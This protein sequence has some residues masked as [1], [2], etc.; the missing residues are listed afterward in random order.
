MLLSIALSG[1][2]LLIALIVIIV[3]ICALITVIFLEKRRP[4]AAF[5][6]CL[7]IIFIPI[8]GFIV[9]IFLGRHF[10]HK[11][12]F[13][14]KG[15]A[16]QAL[17][18]YVEEELSSAAAD[19]QL[20]HKGCGGFE[21]CA[22]ALLK[23]DNALL[24]INNKVDVYRDG[25]EKFEA[26][27]DAIR[28]AKH[29]VHIEYFI[30]RDDELGREIVSV[31]AEKAKEG[32]EVRALFDAGGVPGGYKKLFAPILENCG[33]VR[34]FF[35]SKLPVSPRINFHDHR[36]ILVIDGKLGF[37]GG[38]N[39]GDEYLGK[40]ELGRWRDTH[41]RIA[42]GAVSTLQMRFI[43]DW[44]YT[45]KD[46]PIVIK[47]DDTLYFPDDLLEDYG[48]SVVQIASSGPDTKN[49]P[50]YSGYVDLI[51][52]AQESIYIHT[53][54]F[55]PD[56]GMFEALRLAALSGVDVRI[57]IP[58]KPDHP[59]IYWA[60]RSY[61]GDLMEAGVRGYEY[62][63]GFI[64]SKASIYDGKVFSVGTANW[65]IR[66]FSLNFETQAFVYDAE[67]GAKAAADYLKELETDCREITLEEYRS[68][69]FRQRVLEGISR[70]FSPLL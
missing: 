37:I 57:V 64:H 6:W 31:L 32:V 14:R 42:G 26:L 62:K 47:E 48:Q 29:H 4:T 28:S 67:I 8:V 24:T 52:R 58:C 15:L 18:T 10:Y 50:I 25:Y 66:S 39:I 53:P 51:G 46:K 12:L 16:D 30:I 33:D 56:E 9:Y 41:L 5:A 7:L 3:N 1:T 2:G 65:D 17:N 36:K 69:S 49:R 13:D 43:A 22:V 54:Y 38:F 34:I 11:R 44:N 35:K 59:F 68:R 40:G 21:R 27:K 55:V 19:K 63:D 70:L 23:T 20:W 61:L 60:N 45:A